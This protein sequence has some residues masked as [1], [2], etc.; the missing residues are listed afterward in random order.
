MI[1]FALNK[2]FKNTLYVKIKSDLLSVRLVNT[3]KTIEDKPLVAISSG[4]KK[5]VLTVGADAGNFSSKDGSPIQLINPFEHSRSFINNIE[6]A[7]ATIKYFITGIIGKGHFVNPIII[8]HP[9]EK[10]EGGI[11]QVEAC[12]LRELGKLVGGRDVHIWTGR[13]LKDEELEKL[14]FPTNDGDLYSDW[15]MN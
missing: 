13:E 1:Q 3:K 9:L 8:F 2:F 12:G 11:T 10:I 4:K 5:K 14:D 15:G 6:I 7:S